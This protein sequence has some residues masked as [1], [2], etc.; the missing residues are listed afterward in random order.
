M[1]KFSDRGLVRQG[2]KLDLNLMEWLGWTCYAIN[3]FAT[4]AITVGQ[5]FKEDFPENIVHGNIWDLEDYQGR[6]GLKF[7]IFLRNF[8]LLLLLNVSNS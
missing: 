4:F 6:R 7:N 3:V 2:G 5:V 1:I 8:F